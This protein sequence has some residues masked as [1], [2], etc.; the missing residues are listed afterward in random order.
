MVCNGNKSNIS[1]SIKQ[2]LT[3]T[4]FNP[5]FLF[6]RKRN[7]YNRIPLINLKHAFRMKD[8]ELQQRSTTFYP[9]FNQKRHTP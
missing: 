7:E 3:Q 2:I 1:S 4:D 5:Y 6:L 8:N 9:S